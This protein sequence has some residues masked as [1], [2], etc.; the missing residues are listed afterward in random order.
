MGFT[1]DLQGAFASGLS[2]HPTKGRTERVGEQ[3]SWQSALNARVL[4][5]R[6]SLSNV[7]RWDI[8][9]LRSCC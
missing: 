7:K 8:N 4:N 6:L 5:W 1:N 2:A 3:T 9:V